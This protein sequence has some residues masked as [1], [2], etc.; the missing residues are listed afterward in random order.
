VEMHRIG[1]IGFG[2]VGQAFAKGL[3]AHGGIK[4]DVFDIRFNDDGALLAARMDARALGVALRNNMSDLLLANDCIISAVTCENALEVARSSAAHI[5]AGKLFVDLNT[6]APRVKMNIYDIIKNRGGEFI[7]VA[8]LGAIAS[9][10]FKSP[11]LACGQTAQKF[12]SFLNTLG[13][14]IKVLSEKIGTASSMK[15]LR[16]VFA[17]GVESLLIE[18]LTAAHKCDLME[19]LMD[20]VVSHMDKTSFLDIAQTW[21][22]TNVVHARRR[23]E[24]MDHVIETLESLAVSPIMSRATRERLNACAALGLNERLKGKAPVDYRDAIR[25]MAE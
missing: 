14:D 17:K 15:M 11:M 22:T 4:I 21:I 2:E 18:M 8:I 12:A 1:I 23:A 13:F 19:P 20:E 25:L 10:G 5:T 7:E 16:S 6:V 9:Y 24:E 3:A